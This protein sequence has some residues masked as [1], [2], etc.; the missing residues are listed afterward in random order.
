VAEQNQLSAASQSGGQQARRIE[1]CRGDFQEVSRLIER[2]WAENTHQALL[3]PAD[4]LAWCFEYPGASLSLAPALYDGAMPLAFAAAFPRRVCLRGREL[5]LV[6]VTL[7]TVAAEYKKRG[8]GIVLWNELV[9]RARAAGFDGMVNYCAEGESMNSMILGCCG[10]LKLPTAR[11]YTIPYWSRMLQPRKVQSAPAETAADVVERFLG[12]AAPIA[13]QTPLARSW[14]PEEAEWQ[15]QRRFGSIVAELE[16][17]PRRGMLTGYILPVANAIRTKCLMVED[18][19]WGDLE[20]Q[21]RDSLVKAFL[22]RAILGGAQVAV[23]P[24]LGYADLAPFHAARFRPSQRVLHAYLTI[25]NGE[26]CT[27]A[28]PSMYLD[29]I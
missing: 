12:L 11:A 5:N 14:S 16:S 3:Y 28:L 6:I 10:L 13:K 4:F 18:V 23:L 9:T 22:D 19:L 26:P 2:S 8:Y 7:L 25:W 21:E 29:V 20:P 24:L 1:D 17:G 15:C 27:E